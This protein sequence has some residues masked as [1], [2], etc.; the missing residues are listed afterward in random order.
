MATLHNFLLLAFVFWFVFLSMGTDFHFYRIFV[1]IHLFPSSSAA[2]TTPSNAL[3]Q[4]YTLAY[5]KQITAS[6]HFFMR[7]GCWRLIRTYE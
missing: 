6:S 3:T 7:L 2:V 5:L 1:K 4:T